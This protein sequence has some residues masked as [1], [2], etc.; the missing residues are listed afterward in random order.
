MELPRSQDCPDFMHRS[1]PMLLSKQMIA[2][3]APSDSLEQMD[4]EM[5]LEEL[6]EVIESQGGVLIP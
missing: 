6:A 5:L 4:L 2:E 3:R 1:G